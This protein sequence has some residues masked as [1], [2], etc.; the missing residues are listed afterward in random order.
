MN[1]KTLTCTIDDH[2][3]QIILDR[4]PANALNEDMLQDLYQVFQD[5]EGNDQVSVV[6]ISGKG[7]FFVAGADIE[8]MA[9]MSVEEA[10]QFSSFGSKVFRAIETLSKPVIA[11]INGYA[12]GGGC[13]LALAC[14]IRLASP[15][16]LIGQPE[17]GLGIIPGFAGT[18]RLPR[19]IGRSKAKELIFTGSSLTGQEALDLNLVNRLIDPDKLLLEAR[20]L[21]KKI[22]KNSQAAVAYAKA[23]INQGMDVDF[24]TANTLEANHFAMCFATDDQREGM[25]AFLNKRKATFKHQKEAL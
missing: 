14:D 18:Q 4:P 1:Y 21:A 16:A 19:L 5:L 8:A 22:L 9:K 7:K 13:E 3:G 23:A 11:A 24:M 6:I 15:K 2:I 20:D 10:R 12:L 25:D 17:V